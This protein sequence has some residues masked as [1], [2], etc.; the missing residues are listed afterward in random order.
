[1]LNSLNENKKKK[2]TDKEGSRTF[3][4][5]MNYVTTNCWKIKSDKR[6]RRIHFKMERNLFPMI[7]IHRNNIVYSTRVNG[8]TVVSNYDHFEVNSKN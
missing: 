1:M 2:K 3:P 8:R 6:C 4:W 7:D 5:T